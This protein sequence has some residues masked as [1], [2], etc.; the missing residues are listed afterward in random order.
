MK[1][2]NNKKIWK[3][4]LLDMIV[5][6]V[7]FCGLYHQFLFNGQ[8]YAYADVGADTI[9][10]YLPM[11]VFEVN[12]I[13]E[14]TDGTYSLQFGLGK[15]CDGLLSKYLNPAE[16]PLLLF[17]E[18]NLHIGLLVSLYLKYALI[19]LFALF[20]FR[21]LLKNEKAAAV[22]ALLWTFS[23]YAVLWGQ[24][25]SFLK[26]ILCFT[27]AVY[28]FQ[29]FLEGD[30]KQFLLIPAMA[31][32]AGTSYYHLYITCFFLLFY[33]VAYLA[34]HGYR[35]TQ[36]LKKAGWFV[37]AMIPALCMA[38]EYLL[39]SM[40]T[41]LSSSRTGAVTASLDLGSL[42]YSP[43]EIFAFAVRVLSNNLMWAGSKFVGPVN[44]YECAI[45]SVSILFL[46][47]L[48]YLLQRKNWK[49]VLCITVI[50][51]VLLCMPV[52]SRI[53][54]FASNTQRWT[55]LLCFG[56]VIAIG[57]A[58]TDVWEHRK[59][60]GFVK[61]FW[62]SVIMTDALLVAVAAVLYRAHI[63]VGG[64][65]LRPKTCVVLCVIVALY[66]IV[67][68]LMRKDRIVYFVL[69]AAVAA[70][71]VLGNYAT[72][73][74]REN[75]SIAQWYE[76]MYNDGTEQV[77][78]WIKSQDDSIYR[79]NKTYI[80]GYYTDSLIQGYNGL[81]IYSSTNSA[82]LIDLA[83][84]YGYVQAGHRIRFD[85][86]DMLANTMLGVKYII[87]ESG[88]EM[89]PEYF[90]KIYEDG[91]YE[92]YENLNW[93]GFGYLYQEE[94]SE[95]LANDRNRLEKVMLLSEY[96]YSTDEA[97]KSAGTASGTETVDLAPM[98]TSWDRC[99]VDAG[100]TIQVTGTDGYM[101]LYFDMPEIGENWL[102]SG[103]RIKMTAQTGSTIRMYTSSETQGFEER[104]YGSA[105]YE[106]GA[107]VCYVDSNVLDVP[108]GICLDLSYVQQDI[109]IES[110]E[111]ILVDE[112]QLQRQLNELQERSVTDFRQD[113]NV[114]YASVT[115]PDDTAGML[116]VPLI[117][118]E[119]W[120]ASVDGETVPLENI[121]G[122]LLGIE[123]RPGQHEV[124]LVYRNQVYTWGRILSIV[125]IAAYLLVVVLWKKRTAAAADK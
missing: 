83:Q 71:L 6:T 13:K 66:H 9:D 77:V 68:L 106:A 46:F 89:D 61:V 111:L 91:S 50:C 116:C 36:I 40:Q 5:A 19:C 69:I 31:L 70:E 114:F 55:Y 82:A 63:Y 62:R 122:G 25:Y 8:M 67:F 30:K 102:V 100:D 4:Y 119:Q 52:V 45:L 81:G 73:N 125:S 123:I 38:G 110:V 86:S 105:G 93:L 120:E 64:W 44:Y 18:E 72:V 115:N 10:Q 118:D 26:A 117:Y 103:V 54:V 1:G 58:L 35:F 37:L 42:F 20:F 60:E 12:S 7:I 27:V 124:R 59:E 16:L 21:H 2:K 109:T 104:N 17:G 76:D 65:L 28:G 29:M 108:S 41:F 96:Y 92:V 79:V 88:T 75:I 87:A 43:K 90:E 22:C 51:T 14:G 112:E 23:G 24:H 48:V 121:N 15:Y 57:L 74:D 39:P 3:L 98:L 11:T 80:S 56:Q 101:K 49:R 47:S 34:F 33:G 94:T 107:G 78:D 97:E 85:S 95:I 53:L 99:E 32:L 84:S 113:G